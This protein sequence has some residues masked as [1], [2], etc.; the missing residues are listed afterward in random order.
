MKQK[1]ITI[2]G[3]IA[4]DKDGTLIIGRK[5]PER[6]HQVGAW[7]GFGQCMHLD[8][9]LFKDVTWETE[10]VDVEITIRVKKN[11]E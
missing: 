9:E 8:K 2:D 11:I 1:S 3:C 5:K 6:V 7:M 4:R 10:P